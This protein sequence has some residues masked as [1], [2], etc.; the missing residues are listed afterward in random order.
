LVST[1]ITSAALG[2]ARAAVLERTG[3]ESASRGCRR[4]FH[5]TATSRWLRT[6]LPLK[7]MQ[8]V[9]SRS[10]STSLAEKRTAV[11]SWIALLRTLDRTRR[12]D[13]T[14]GEGGESAPER[15][16]DFAKRRDRSARR[17]AALRSS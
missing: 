6:K 1:S 11:V 8:A 17:G 14:I 3:T 13:R 5:F 15:D 12:V 10:I 2:P 16:E 9:H 4:P 7:K